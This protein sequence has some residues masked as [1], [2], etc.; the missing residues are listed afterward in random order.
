MN[1]LVLFLAL[2]QLF[3]CL[4]QSYVIALEGGSAEYRPLE[5]NEQLPLL[6]GTVLQGEEIIVFEHVGVSIWIQCKDGQNVEIKNQKIDINPCPNSSKTRYQPIVR[7][8]SK[9][10]SLYPR[11]IYPRFGS[12]LNNR[13]EFRWEAVQN[14]TG[15]LVFLK[16]IDEKEVWQKPYQTSSTT[17]P[18]PESEEA[19]KPGVNYDLEVRVIFPSSTGPSSEQELLNFRFKAM[20]PQQQTLLRAE[21][22]ALES[23]ELP[24]EA[25]SYAKAL[26]YYHYGALHD[27]LRELE[28]AL[29]NTASTLLKVEIHKLL[30]QPKKAE[31]LIESARN[32]CQ[33]SSCLEL[34][35]LLQN[36]E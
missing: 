27:A 11:I 34:E 24:V 5:S 14:A 29:P 17:L 22:N 12:L 21:I 32:S 30:A 36:S 31:Q 15:Y 8:P 28:N 25:I 10:I 18:Y 3:N 1:K 7:L 35:T 2:T 26:R 4:A 13:P 19:L 9:G 6:E 23:S 16:Y 33:G 20:L